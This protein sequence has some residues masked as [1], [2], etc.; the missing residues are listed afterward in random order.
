IDNNSRTGRRLLRDIE[1]H[2][3][4]ARIV[5]ERDHTPLPVPE[6]ELISLGQFKKNF[7]DAILEDLGLNI[8]L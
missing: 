8:T 1:K 2:P 4:I 6:E 5:D 3:R 7:E